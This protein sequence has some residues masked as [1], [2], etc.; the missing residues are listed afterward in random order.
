M[1]TDQYPRDQYDPRGGSAS[2]SAQG[3]GEPGADE[4]RRLLAEADGRSRTL[5]AAIPA[6]F[7]TYGMLCVTGSFAVIVLH[8]A[9]LMPEDPNFS[10]RLLGIIFSLVWV[11]VSL[12]PLF[13]VRDRWRRGLNRRWLVLMVVW[14]LLWGAAMFLATTPAALIIA[15]AFLVL[16]VVAVT[17]EAAALKERSTVRGVQGR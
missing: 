16:F 13:I 3:S 4:A 6:A 7:I 11:V 17:G 15:P 2:S 12:V 5:P 10:P 8:I 9:D 1:S 14:G